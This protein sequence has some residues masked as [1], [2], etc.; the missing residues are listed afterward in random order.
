MGPDLKTA[1]DSSKFIVA[2]FEACLLDSTS[3]SDLTSQQ[4]D[5]LMPG[6]ASGLNSAQ[7]ESSLDALNRTMARFGIKTLEQGAQFLAQLGHESINL[8]VWNEVLS[9]ASAK[10]QYWSAS[11]K[12]LGLGATQVS[13][14]GITLKFTYAQPTDAKGNVLKSKKLDLYWNPGNPMNPTQPPGTTLAGSTKVS[15]VSQA[16][17]YVA[18]STRGKGTYSF[19]LTFS[20]QSAW[21]LKT[22]IAFPWLQVVD[23]ATKKPVY[24]LKNTLGNWSPQDAVDFKGHGPIQLTGRGNYQLLANARIDPSLAELMTK[25]QAT[26]GDRTKP[27]P[28]MLAAGCFW[29]TLNPINA[30]IDKYGAGSYDRNGTQSTSANGTSATFET[31]YKVSQVVNGQQP[32]DPSKG[33][34]LSG[35]Q[36][37][38][39]PAFKMSHGFPVA[40]NGLADRLNRYLKIRSLLLDPAVRPLADATS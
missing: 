33:R 32:P 36:N 26:L 23:P 40:P 2:S 1:N 39:P 22:T 37:Y 38:Q 14:K 18:G 31:L 11:A 12:W 35:W 8:G 15:G 4:L 6:W 27:L 19:S 30:A 3:P 20:T 21:P 34:N 13:N 5:D 10:T 28:G 16:F 7:S 17:S 25:P 24:G 9:D 29:S